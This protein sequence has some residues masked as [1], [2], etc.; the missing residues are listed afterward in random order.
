MP[1][2]CNLLR[3]GPGA[4]RKILPLL[5]HAVLSGDG[6]RVPVGMRAWRYAILC[7]SILGRHARSPVGHRMPQGRSFLLACC[8]RRKMRKHKHKKGVTVLHSSSPLPQ[9]GSG[10]S[11][12]SPGKQA[13]LAKDEQQAKFSPFF[14]HPSIHNAEDADPTAFSFLPRRVQAPGG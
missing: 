5:R 2:R 8:P 10:L 4:T 14:L 11:L 7:A 3:K 1:Q 9:F 12:L 13:K 6:A